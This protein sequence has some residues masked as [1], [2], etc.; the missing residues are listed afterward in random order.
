MIRGCGRTDFQEGDARTLYRSVHQQIY[1]LPDENLIYSGH[2][3]QGHFWST[4]A[5]E[6]R[7]NP[8]LKINHSEEDFV[9]MMSE[10]KLS[11][12]KMIHIAVPANQR[13]GLWES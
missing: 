7:Y 9:R 3:Y 12:P 11:A 1:S 2:N 8:R 10:L 6:K 13:G 4:V 5:E